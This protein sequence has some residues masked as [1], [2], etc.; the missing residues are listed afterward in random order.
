MKSR[1]EGQRNGA[2]LIGGK[3]DKY[4]PQKLLRGLEGYVE[5][6]DAKR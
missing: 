4:A 6:G 2:V 1:S 3:L 5:Q